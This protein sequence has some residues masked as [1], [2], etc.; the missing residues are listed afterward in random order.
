MLYFYT[1]GAG[2]GKSYALIQKIKELSESN[3]EMCVI[4]PEQYSYESEKI[5]YKSLGISKFNSIDKFSFKTLSQ[6]IIKKY[7]DSRIKKEYANDNKKTI[8][9]NLAMNQVYAGM[10]E[11]AGFYKKQYKKNG[12]AEIVSDF[13][14]EIKQTGMTSEM[15]ELTKEQFT[16]RLHEKMQ[17]IFAIYREYERLMNEYNL[18]DSLNDITE[19]AHTA[20]VNKYFKGKTVF[21]DEFDDFT[22]DQY[23]MLKVILSDADDVYDGLH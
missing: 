9:V 6:D 15:L 17:D 20:V 11:N 21:I 14:T 2:G 5:L 13:I 22:G 18:K 16:G 4:V 8:M 3:T 1:G 23:Q 10:P 19:S 12:F 7:G